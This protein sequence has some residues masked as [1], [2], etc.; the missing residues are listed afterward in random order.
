MPFLTLEV[1][2]LADGGEC[3]QSWCDERRAG[4]PAVRTVGWSCVAAIDDARGGVDVIHGTEDESVSGV[5]H[6]MGGVLTCY[7]RRR[8]WRRG[9]RDLENFLKCCD[10]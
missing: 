2:S 3:F 8:C 6:T 9:Q 1:A 10:L 7:G 4:G 5:C